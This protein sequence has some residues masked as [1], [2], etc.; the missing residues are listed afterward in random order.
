MYAVQKINVLVHED[1]HQQYIITVKRV[2][3]GS[4]YRNFIHLI[5]GTFGE[6]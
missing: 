4:G 3:T 2:Y 1:K 5:A 6:I